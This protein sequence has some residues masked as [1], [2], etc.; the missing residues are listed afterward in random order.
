MIIIWLLFNINLEEATDSIKLT[1]EQRAAIEQ[2][3]KPFRRADYH[4]GRRNPSLEPTTGQTSTSTATQAPAT[5]RQ[6]IH[7]IGD[8]KII[9]ERGL[10]M[11]GKG[12]LISYSS[13]DLMSVVIKIPTI[14]KSNFPDNCSEAFIPIKKSYENKIQ[15]YEN[16]LTQILKPSNKVTKK[17]LCEWIGGKDCNSANKHKRKKRFVASH[18]NGGNSSSCIG[19]ST[20]TGN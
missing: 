13:I 15:H 19:S 12:T 8:Y 3:D 4:W 14:E 10:A 5:E 9:S 6:D 7:N 17:E 18:S 11:D 2:L 1:A 16:T 20:G